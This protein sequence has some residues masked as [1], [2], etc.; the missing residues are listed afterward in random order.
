V[1]PNLSK[2]V[3]VHVRKTAYFLKETVFFLFILNGI[4]HKS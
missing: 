1:Q 2:P 3:V 4:C